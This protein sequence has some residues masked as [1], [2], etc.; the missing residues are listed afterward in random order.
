MLGVIS[1]AVVLLLLVSALIGGRNSPEESSD[2]TGTTTAPSVGA[3]PATGT[4]APT[5]E[6]AGFGDGTY[7]VG[8]DVQPGLYRSAGGSFCMWKRLSA[9]SGDSDAVLAWEW[10]DGQAYAEVLATDVAFSTDGCGRW[11][12]VTA[13][14]PDVSDGFDDGTYLVGSDI[15]PGLYRSAGGS[16]CMWKRLSAVSGD[17]DAVLAWEWSDGQAYAEVLPTDVAFSTD[18]CG[19]WSRS[20]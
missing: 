14:G 13:G 1:A 9:V 8:S 2:A 6:P 19:T 20:D 7:L 16:F 10:S 11:T 15:Q 17:S 12:A 3:G 5:P 18:D 4:A